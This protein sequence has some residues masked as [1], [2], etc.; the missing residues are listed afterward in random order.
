MVLA[1]ANYR[2]SRTR[3]SQNRGCRSTQ[4]PVPLSNWKEYGGIEYGGLPVESRVGSPHYGTP[5]LVR[6]VKYE[7]V[8]I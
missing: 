8:P 3:R 4:T 1:P 2:G 5:T 7:I 6:Q